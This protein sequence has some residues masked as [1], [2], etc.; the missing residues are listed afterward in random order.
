VAVLNLLTGTY[1][2]VDVSGGKLDGDQR[3]MCEMTLKDGKVVYDW[4][5]RMGTD[6]RELGES[7]GIRDAD[8]IVYPP[9]K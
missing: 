1:G 9:A 3:L 4:N 5:G 2:Y 7:Y 6:Y 8:D